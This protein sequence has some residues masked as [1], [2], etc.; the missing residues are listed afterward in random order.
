M[1]PTS[2]AALS[3]MAARWN[4][5]STPGANAAGSD[6]AALVQRYLAGDGAAFDL[7]VDR[8]RAF[9]YRVV[10]GVLPNIEEARDITQEVFIQAFRGIRRFRHD[11]QFAT[12]LY[13]I[14]V[15]RALDAARAASRRSRL[16]SPELLSE[17]STSTAEMRPED[18]V[19][20]ADEAAQVRA[21]L[22]L[23]KPQHRSV[24]AL[25]YLED[26]TIEEMVPLLACS[27]TAV[28]VRLHRARKAFRTAWS[29]LHNGCPSPA[30]EL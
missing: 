5:A 27:E 1:K 9:V 22:A 3:V 2:G 16:S 30:E 10:L 26:L 29:Q 25:K 8:Y 24:L 19:A 7:L 28:K 17:R 4:T 12:W 21:A 18:A 11:S 14:A 15:N 6:D 23:C 20:E 13:R